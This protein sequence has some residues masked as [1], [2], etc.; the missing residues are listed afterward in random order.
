MFNR[1][2]GWKVKITY[3]VSDIVAVAVEFSSFTD[4]NDLDLWRV[5]LDGDGWG[6][7]DWSLCRRF[8]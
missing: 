5:D 2:L 6:S 4:F 1:F 7:S 8:D 3:V